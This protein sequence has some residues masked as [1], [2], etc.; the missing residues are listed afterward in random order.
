MIQYVGKIYFEYLINYL[1]VTITIINLWIL[2][3]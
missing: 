2:L 3:L 1:I